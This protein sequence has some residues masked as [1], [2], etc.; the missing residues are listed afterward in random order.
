[1][2]ISF[3]TSPTLNQTYSYLG[4]VWLWNGTTWQAV[5]TTTYSNLDGGKA[6]TIYGGTVPIAAGKASGF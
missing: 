3:P 2:P 6:N 5:G 4:K 1:M